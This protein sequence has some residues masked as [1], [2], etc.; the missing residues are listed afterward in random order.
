M[1]K[2]NLILCGALTLYI[3]MKNSFYDSQQNYLMETF[4]FFFLRQGYSV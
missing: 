3:R 2:V 4:F 1:S